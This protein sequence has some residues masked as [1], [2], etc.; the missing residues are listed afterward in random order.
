MFSFQAA[1]CSWKALLSILKSSMSRSCSHSSL[2]RVS[3]TRVLP[4]P[5]VLLFVSTVWVVSVQ[6]FQVRRSGPMITGAT[7]ADMAFKATEE[8]FYGWV[9]TYLTS[10]LT[11]SSNL[12]ASFAV[13]HVKNTFSSPGVGAVNF[14]GAAAPGRR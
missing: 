13:P 10:W 12:A 8:S 6:Y 3:S 4:A 7:I 11:V 1:T 5:L 14:L 9:F 2:T